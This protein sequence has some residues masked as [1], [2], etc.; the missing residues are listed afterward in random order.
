MALVTP[1]QART[2]Q[3]FAA[4]VGG[5]KILVADAS[6]TSRASIANA[7]CVLGAKMA[8]IILSQ[9]YADAEAQIETHKPKIVICDYDLGKRCGLDLIQKLKSQNPDLR[10]CLFVLVTGNT[11]QSAVARAAEED[12]DTFVL[13]PFTAEV[14]RNSI[15]KAAATKVRPPA[16]LVEI[17]KGKELLAQA[18][19]DEAIT[20]LE[21]ARKMDSSP[22]LAC[23]Y[24]GQAN[25]MKKVQEGAKTSYSA[26][27][28]Y[29]KIHYKCMVGMYELLMG[30]KRFA[31][32]YDIVK[33][34]AHYFPANPQRMS[35]VLRLA[36]VTASYEDVERYYRIFTSM[37]QRDPEMVKYI[38]AALVVCGKHYIATRSG[39]RALELF[40][41]AAVTAAGSSRILREVIHA[42]VEADMVKQ[43]QPFLA[44]FPAKA[45]TGPDYL[46]VELLIRHRSG[47]L[48]DAIARGREILSRGVEDPLIYLTLI[49]AS[50]EAGFVP[51]AE[52]LVRKASEKYAEQKSEFEQALKN[53]QARV[54]PAGVKP[55]G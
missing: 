31:E 28:Q 52:E 4:Y 13:K 29:N 21:G 46:A 12:V 1:E 30:E 26:G 22:A 32:A 19:Y 14:L 24:L 50:A 10:D 33:R 53:A 48:G 47:A 20:V 34:I 43:A 40:E 41:K 27:L 15:L 6:P 7:L 39:S 54:T 25:L 2:Q 51:A 37:E 8:Q 38:C 11:S 18:K 5:K 55:P 35:S 42:L 17:N 9:N 16:Y 3:F 23:F 49:R 45:Q 36:I 44:R